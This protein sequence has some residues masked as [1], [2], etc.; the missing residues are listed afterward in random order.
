MGV[1]NN[2]HVP[3][4]S[5]PRFVW[6]VIEFFIIVGISVGIAMNSVNYF[7]QLGFTAQ[8]TNWIFWGI[9]GGVFLVYYIPIRTLIFKKPILK[10]I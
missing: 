6:Y 4:E 1:H 9:V 7:T 3:E 10:N 2:I 5:F 8:M